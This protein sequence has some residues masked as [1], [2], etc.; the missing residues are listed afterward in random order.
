MFCDIKYFGI[1]SDA[2]K[3]KGN[4]RETLQLYFD[5]MIPKVL[6]YSIESSL[7]S[8]GQ[9]IL[10]FKNRQEKPNFLKIHWMSYVPRNVNK[11]IVSRKI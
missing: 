4:N 7:F 10:L 3:P 5:V 11:T 1:F 6:F 2:Q 9:H 8:T